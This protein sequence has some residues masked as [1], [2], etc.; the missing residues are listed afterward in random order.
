MSKPLGRI[1]FVGVSPDLRNMISDYSKYEID[2]FVIRRETKGAIIP[3]DAVETVKFIT[4]TEG[5]KDSFEIKGPY[6]NEQF[7][8]EEQSLNDFVDTLFMQKG[9]LAL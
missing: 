3:A 5:S 8:L 1:A 4:G 2:T 9:F 7:A 6:L